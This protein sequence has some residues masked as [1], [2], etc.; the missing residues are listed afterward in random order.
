MYWNT[1]SSLLRASPTSEYYFMLAVD[2][3][4]YPQGRD[5]MSKI[6]HEGELYHH[7]KRQAGI[8]AD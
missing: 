8:Q 6:T 5:F 7:G 2:E 1:L 3:E 4:E